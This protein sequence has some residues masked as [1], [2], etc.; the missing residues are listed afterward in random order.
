MCASGR[1][2]AAR[3]TVVIPAAARAAARR[4]RWIA[5]RTATTGA[6]RR[7]ARAGGRY[8]FRLDGDAAASRPG[9]ALSARRAA[10]A[11][12]LRRSLDAFRWTDARLARAHA[13]R[14]GASTRCT[15][16]RSRAKA[17]GAPRRRSSPELARH[18]HHR[19]RDDADRGVRRAVRLGLRRR[20]SLSPRR[21]STARRRSARASSIA[22]TRSASASSSTSSTTTSGPTAITWRSSRRD[23]FTDQLQERLGPGDQLR[24]AGAGPRAIRRRTPATGSTSSTSTACASTRRRTSRTRRRAHVIADIV[25]RGARPRRARPI[26]RRRR[27]RAAAHVPCPRPAPSGGYGVDALWNDDSI[28]PRRWR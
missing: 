28:I 20:R 14:P 25:A 7:G 5:R 2:H 3:W 23:Y 8:W 24:R 22:R 17:R 12:R 15:S 16:A 6:V 10:R 27:K 19:D 21:T 9:V 13:D 26:Y 11:V 1:R 18:R 4:R